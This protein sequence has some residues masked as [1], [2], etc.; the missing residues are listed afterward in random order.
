M[1]RVYGLSHGLEQFWSLVDSHCQ[2]SLNQSIE[3]QY[4]LTA[5]IKEIQLKFATRE[6]MHWINGEGIPFVLN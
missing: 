4:I 1:Q 5:S 3:Y 6:Q 2:A